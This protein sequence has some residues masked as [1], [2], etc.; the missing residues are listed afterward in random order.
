M[1][2]CIAVQ[3]AGLVERLG[4]LTGFEGSLADLVDLLLHRLDLSGVVLVGMR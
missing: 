3:L 2:R 1:M 4:A